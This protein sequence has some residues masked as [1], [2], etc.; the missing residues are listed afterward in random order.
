MCTS[1]SAWWGTW[2][3]SGAIAAGS[4]TR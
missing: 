1:Y 2:R 3:T 4:T